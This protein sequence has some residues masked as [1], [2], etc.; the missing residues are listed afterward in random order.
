M[1]HLEIEADLLHRERYVLVGLHLDLRLEFCPRRLRGIWITLVIAASPL[2]A[3]RTL[4][5]GHR[6]VLLRGA[7]PA[8]RLRI[9]DGFVDRI[10]RRRLRRIRFDAIPVATPRQLNELD[11]GRRDVESYDRS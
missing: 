11:G 7:R 8:Y 5:C 6:R 1:G 4:C 2:I 9:D 3:R 10:G